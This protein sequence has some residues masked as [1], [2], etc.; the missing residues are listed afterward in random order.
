MPPQ[1]RMAGIVVA[2]ESSFFIST[3][4]IRCVVFLVDT[5]FACNELPFS[6]VQCDFCRFVT[7][8]QTSM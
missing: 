2:G 6:T 4:F 8:V 3:S 1:L 5:C 7:V